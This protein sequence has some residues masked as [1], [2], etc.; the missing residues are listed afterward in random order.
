MSILVVNII[1]PV[2]TGCIVAYFTH[3]LS[4]RDK[5]NRQ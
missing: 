4:N 5:N 1:A 3:W 2:I